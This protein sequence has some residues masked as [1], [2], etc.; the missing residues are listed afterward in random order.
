MDISFFLIVFF[1]H[2]TQQSAAD[3]QELMKL[4]QLECQALRDLLL[5]DSVSMPSS[6]SPLLEIFNTA[7]S[8]SGDSGTNIEDNP[9]DESDIPL[10]LIKDLKLK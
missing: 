5:D 9:L 1:N 7:I 4:S 6:P 10:T 2:K 8:D 3:V